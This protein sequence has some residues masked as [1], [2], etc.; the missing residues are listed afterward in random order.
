MASALMV[1][2]SET[3]IAASNYQ[4]IIAKASPP[5]WN[6]I[7]GGVALFVVLMAVTTYLSSARSKKIEALAR[8]RG[9]SF[10]AK[11]VPADGTLPVGCSLMDEGRRPTVGNVLEVVRTDELELQLFDFGY[12]TGTGRMQTTVSQ[13]VTRIRAPL[14][15]LPGF[16]LFPQ[17]FGAEIRILFGGTD[18]NFSDSPNF[19]GKFVLRGGDEPAVRRLFNPALRQGLEPFGRLTIEGAKHTLFIF[20]AFHNIKPADIPAR[21]EDDKRILALFFEAQRSVS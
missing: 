18:I 21:I 2:V 4:S 14:L 12:T 10:H 3:A 16:C 20:R 8:S 15:E 11:F 5:P 19:S 9:F 6:I 13:T 7:F 1:A 17:T